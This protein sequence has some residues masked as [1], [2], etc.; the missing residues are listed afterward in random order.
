ME[1]A[2]DAPPDGRLGGDRRGGDRGRLPLLRG[3]P[4]DAVHGAARGLRR[5]APRR[6]RRVRQRGERAR[7]RRHGVGRGGDGRARRDR[8]DRTGALAHAG[9]VLGAHARR[10]AARRV[11]HGARP[12]RLLPG[13]ARRRTRRLPPHRARA[14]S[15]CARRSSSCSAPSSSPTSGAIPCCSTATI[16]SRTP[17]RPWRSSRS[18]LAAPDKDWAVDGTGRARGGP[19]HAL[20]V[21][22][23]PGAKGIDAEASGS[24]RRE[25]RAHGRGGGARRGRVHRRTRS[26]SSSRSARSRASRGTRARAPRAK[27]CASAS[28]ARSRSGRSRARRSRRP[29]RARA[30]WPCSS[31]TPAR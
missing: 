30:A 24:A 12:V 4:D 17:R 25:A 6:G 28:S 19:R 15:T 14:A 16:C 10:A 2:G 1:S 13:D 5:E 26:S 7:G 29:R 18:A 3:L 11:Q 22:M 8:F 9:V 31:R 21:G 23:Q 27:V 20:A